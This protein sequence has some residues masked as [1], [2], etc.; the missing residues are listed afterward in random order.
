MILSEVCSPSKIL[1]TVVPGT[2]RVV[3]FRPYPLFW[4]PPY[5]HTD[6]FKSCQPSIGPGLTPLGPQSRFGDNLHTLRVFCPHIWE[7]G[8]K[9]VKVT[10]VADPRRC[11]CLRHT[12]HLAMSPYSIL[13]AEIHLCTSHP[14]RDY[15]PT[16]LLFTLGD[17]F[18]RSL[19]CL[20]CNNRSKTM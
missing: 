10:F 16:L 9:R 18:T 15:R 20:Q 8:S 3:Y 13:V 19:A 6:R 7:C 2:K 14:L 17:V 11:G 1:R 4:R 12:I 5:C